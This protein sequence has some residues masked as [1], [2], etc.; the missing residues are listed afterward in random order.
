MTS[1]L[2]VPLARICVLSSGDAVLVD[3]ETDGGSAILNRKSSKEV[4]RGH[5]EVRRFR[6]RASVLVLFLATAIVG[7]V[8]FLSTG[9][10]SQ[11]SVNVVAQP[12]ADAPTATFAPALA[13]PTATNAPEL[14]QP[15]AD[16]AAPEPNPILLP[17]VTPTPPF[18][19]SAR[20]AS[21]SG[22][23][24]EWQTWNNCGPA[25]MAMAL[26]YFGSDLTQADIAFS[27]RPNGED[28]N[29][30][31]EE[32][33]AFARTQGLQA[34]TRV[35]GDATILKRLLS[36]GLPVLVEVWLEPEPDDGF[37]HY[38]L[39]TGYDNE[40]QE[41]IAYDSYVA[42]GLVDPVGT[43][44]GI[45]VPYQV[46]DQ[47]WPVFNRTYV[48]LYRPDEVE[49]LR[50]ALGE[51]MDDTVMWT[52]ALEHAQLETQEDPND[53]FAW[54][55]QGSALAALQRFEEAVSAYDQATAIGLPWR[56]LWYQFGPLE[57]YYRTGRFA[58][59]VS[60]VEQT[61]ATTTNVEELY[62]WRGLG[63]AALG[64]V[65]QARASF[66][67]ALTLRPSYAEAAQALAA[68]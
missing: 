33:A 16:G 50:F 45:S 35:N 51:Q 21:L 48:V 23:T 8:L 15:P 29:V 31:A 61:L 34:I 26:S 55:N 11:L 41:W 42:E 9:S 57:A 53:A 7:I 24:H 27:L 1:V 37:G 20:A 58:Q 59:L 66:S 67:T 39:L 65:E 3:E 54:F 64:D 4:A 36:N 63:L 25:T 22:L 44:A 5:S 43:Y 30:S 40:T 62:Y 49:T 68:Q 6:A 32:L 56:M 38:R 13:T 14:L 18:R 60:T 19:S 52:R 17:T 2:Y 10:R 28:K 47:Q 12:L 46:L